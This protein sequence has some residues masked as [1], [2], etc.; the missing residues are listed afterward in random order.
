[1]LESI[2]WRPIIDILAEQHSILT[3]FI[4]N[5]HKVPAS[6]VQDKATMILGPTE[7][8]CFYCRKRGYGAGRC[9][10]NPKRDKLCPKCGKSG[11]GEETSWSKSKFCK[12]AKLDG[13]KSQGHVAILGTIT[14]TELTKTDSSEDKNLSDNYVFNVIVDPQP[15]TND[16]FLAVKK[17]ADR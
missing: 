17:E 7:K 8:I 1:M 5:R 6:H 9:P 2:T 15:C 14:T 4:K 13:K 12:A 11:H 10:E 16:H 3:L